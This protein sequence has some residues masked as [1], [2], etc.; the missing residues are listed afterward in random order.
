MYGEPIVLRSAVLAAGK[1]PASVSLDDLQ[2]RC[3]DRLYINP[4]DEDPQEIII[5]REMAVVGVK[6]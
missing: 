4:Q 1:L 2:S 5:N 3:Y 6:K